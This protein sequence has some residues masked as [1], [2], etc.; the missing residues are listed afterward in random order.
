MHGQSLTQIKTKHLHFSIHN[1]DSTTNYPYQRHGMQF[2][3]IFVKYFLGIL[4]QKD[5]MLSNTQGRRSQDTLITDQRKYLGF[6]ES[7][8][9]SMVSKAYIHKVLYRRGD[10]LV[11]QAAYREKS[12]YK[13]T[14]IFQAIWLSP[15]YRMQCV[16]C[17][18]ATSHG[19]T[20]G[21]TVVGYKG[22]TEPLQ[23]QTCG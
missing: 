10:P 22:I 23:N 11:T 8:V 20:D 19:L 3:S 21:G 14:Y 1:S 17:W 18:L 5:L 16:L 9:Q 15:H 2:N 12:K 13:F 4:Q 7:T 6:R